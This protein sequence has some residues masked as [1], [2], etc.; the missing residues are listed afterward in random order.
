MSVFLT[1][2]SELNMAMLAARKWCKKSGMDEPIV[3]EI[4]NYLFHGCKVIGGNS[5]ALDFVEAG[6]SEFHLVRTKRL[7]VSGAFHTKLMEPAGERLRKELATVQ[8]KKPLIKL[9]SNYEGDLYDRGNTGRIKANLV[10]Q[11]S[12]P[13]K[14][15]QILNTM[16]LDENLPFETSIQPVKDAASVESDKLTE[17]L[18]QEQDSATEDGKAGDEKKNIKK[19]LQTPDRFYPDVFECGPGAQTGPVLKVI[20]RKAF[21]FYKHIG[22]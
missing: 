10:R 2:K 7:A 13:V 15:E 22:V 17:K 20:N 5:R 3:C 19:K 8:F 21:Q 11:V 6:A 18:V 4:A 16:F 1:R 14:W 9:Y 12:N